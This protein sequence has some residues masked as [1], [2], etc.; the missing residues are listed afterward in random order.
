MTFLQFAKGKSRLDAAVATVFSLIAGVI[1]TFGLNVT[2]L[3][4]LL[5]GA[6]AIFAGALSGAFW[7][8]HVDAHEMVGLIEKANSIDT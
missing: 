6:A 7:R 3:G 2:T 5:M 4:E 8:S 1:L